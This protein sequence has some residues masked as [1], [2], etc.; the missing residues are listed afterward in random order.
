MPPIPFDQVQAQVRAAFGKELETIFKE[1]D[2]VPL[3]AA[4][5][6]QAAE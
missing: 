3:A 1:F 2:P 6:A 4:S 5:I